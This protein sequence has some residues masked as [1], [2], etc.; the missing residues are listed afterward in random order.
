MAEIIKI[1]ADLS[2]SQKAMALRINPKLK[3]N[4]RLSTTKFVVDTETGKV[5]KEA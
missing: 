3:M 4:T 2:S 5:I 1:Y